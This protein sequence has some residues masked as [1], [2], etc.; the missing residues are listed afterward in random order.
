MNPF[1]FRH[2]WMVLSGVHSFK[3]PKKKQ[4]IGF[5]I[6]DFGN[7]EK[8][9]RHRWMVLSSP[10]LSFLNGSI[11]PL[12]VIP[13]CFYQESKLLRN[14]WMPDKSA[15]AWRMRK[16]PGY[17]SG[18]TGGK[19]NKSAELQKHSARPLPQILRNLSLLRE[20]LFLASYLL[21]GFYFDSWRR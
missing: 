5:P 3:K 6:K 13:E 19:E 18:T 12:P 16:I 7:D 8:G 10:C 4:K 11:I 9:G 17:G 21:P 1:L 2:P 20:S 15:Q 14:I